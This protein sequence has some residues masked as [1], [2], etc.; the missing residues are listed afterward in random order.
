MSKKIK[1]TFD[2]QMDEDALLH[3]ENYHVSGVGQDASPITLTNVEFDNSPD[4]S[5]ICIA[6]TGIMQGGSGNYTINAHQTILDKELDAIDEDYD[7][8]NFDGIAPASVAPKITTTGDVWV[9]SDFFDITF[10]TS[11][12]EATVSVPGNWDYDF[13]TITISS[14]TDLSGGLW[15][16]VRV[17]LSSSELPLGDYT[18][19]ATS[20]V[21]AGGIPIDPYNN[22]INLKGT[23][24]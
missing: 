15:T 24:V 12:D 11:M 3:K 6:F 20:A 2:S 21:T 14:I 1:I 23:F 7:T 8:S 19:V 13:G 10:D 5:V 22:S 17:T 4:Q 18:F 9:T 16:S